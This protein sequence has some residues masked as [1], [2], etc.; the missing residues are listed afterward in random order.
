MISSLQ[1]KVLRMLV[2]LQGLQSNSTCILEAK[3]GKHDI[4][5][6]KHGILFISLP[7]GSLFKLGI[8]MLL[9]IF[10]WIQCH[11]GHHSK[12]ATP[13]HDLIKT[14]AVR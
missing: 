8:M 7:I 3:P 11:W 2:E 12:S 14:H 5:I 6:R 4:E 1:G 10:V 13:N 9:S